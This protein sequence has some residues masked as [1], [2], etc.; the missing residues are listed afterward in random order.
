MVVLDDADPAKV[1]EGIKIGG[2][3]NSG[4]DCTAS[5]R[6]LVHKKIYDDVMSGRS[7]RSKR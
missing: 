2:Y 1:A 7:R 4:Q 6:M 5:S 3:W